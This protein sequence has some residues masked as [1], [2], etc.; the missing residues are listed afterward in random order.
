MQIAPVMTA[1]NWAVGTFIGVALV[2]YELC[3]Q[4]R[5]RELAGVKQAVEIIDRKK[6]E[7]L[8]K[9]KEAREARARPGQ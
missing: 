3:Q 4:R 8:E 7:K 6:F 2:T 9:M 1:S 5:H